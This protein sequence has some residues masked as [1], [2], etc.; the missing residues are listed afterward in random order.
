M[1]LRVIGAVGPEGPLSSHTRLLLQLEVVGEDGN[2]I[3]FVRL[4]L[5]GADGTQGTAPT[6]TTG[7]F[8]YR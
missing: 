2:V 1:D 8:Q 4:K 7:K 3:V 5:T 6:Q